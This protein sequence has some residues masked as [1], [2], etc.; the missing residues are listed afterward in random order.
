MQFDWRGRAPP[1]S[2]HMPVRGAS[3]D[4]LLGRDPLEGAVEG[5]VEGAVED[6][7]VGNSQEGVLFW[8]CSLIQKT[9]NQQKIES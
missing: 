2:A 3:V 6:V 8:R 7:P 9:N 5:R 1:P 4:P